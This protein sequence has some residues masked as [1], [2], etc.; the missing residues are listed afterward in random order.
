[1]SGTSSNI[2]T[3]EAFTSPICLEV[4]LSCTGFKTHFNHLFCYLCFIGHLQTV[5]PDDFN[6]AHEHTS[7]RINCAYCSTS[8][9]I[10][11][12]ADNSIR[13]LTEYYWWERKK[14]AKET[15]NFVAQVED[16]KQGINDIKA[17]ITKIKEEE[18]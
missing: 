9:L 7:L 15:A 4:F 5:D 10:Y 12:L 17:A 14:L 18:D 8:C 11:I 2:A 3:Q 1:M 13:D 6:F 16:V